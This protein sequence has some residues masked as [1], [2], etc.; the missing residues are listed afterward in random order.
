MKTFRRFELRDSKGRLNAT[1]I[2][3]LVSVGLSIFFFG[4]SYLLASGKI[5]H[6]GM[7]WSLFPSG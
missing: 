4:L 6:P 2:G 1:L 5:P 3:A 7:I